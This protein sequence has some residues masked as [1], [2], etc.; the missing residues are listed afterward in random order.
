MASS[1][2]YSPGAPTTNRNRRTISEGE[3]ITDDDKGT[4]GIKPGTS[5]DIP[6]KTTSVEINP[7]PP[8]EE[9]ANREDTA[10]VGVDLIRTKKTVV[11]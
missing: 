8:V 4:V 2:S 10:K 3:T 5:I 7:I 11:S 9:K 1:T 6:Q